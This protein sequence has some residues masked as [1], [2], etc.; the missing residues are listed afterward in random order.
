MTGYSC[1]W[2]VYVKTEP[3]KIRGFQFGLLSQHYTC[4]PTSC[5]LSFAAQL[6]FAFP[7]NFAINFKTSDSFRT[8]AILINIKQHVPAT[9]SLRTEH[10]SSAFIHLCSQYLNYTFVSRQWLP[11][12][13]L[14]VTLDAT[15]QP[16]LNKEMGIEQIIK[17][18][19]LS[20]FTIISFITFAKN[21]A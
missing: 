17:L 16:T 7:S 3:V 13:V 15:S 21:I 6:T 18:P 9:V 5:Y 14:M 19:S 8:F 4:T 1:A 20:M 2:L 10:Y 12:G 11:V